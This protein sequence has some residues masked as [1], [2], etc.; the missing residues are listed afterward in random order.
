MQ[1]HKWSQKWGLHTPQS[2][3]ARARELGASEYLIQGLLPARSISLLIGDSGLGKSALVY[4]AGICISSGMPF[5]GRET[6]KGSVL[7]ADFEN[8]IVDMDELI[9]R[10]SK[11]IGLP[12]PPSELTLF[13]IND[14]DQHFGETGHEL[15]DVLRDLKPK[16]AII[17]SM[18]SYSRG[19]EE[20]NSAAI[21]MLQSFRDLIR[22]CGT[23]VLLVHHRRKLSRK[24]G[25]SAGPLEKAQ[26]R[27]W[28]QD[29]R[30][31]STLV[32]NSD[33]RL[34][35]DDP[36]LSAVSKDEIALV[37]R[38]FGRIRG[39]IGPVYLAREMDEHGDPMAYR[40]ITGAELL[41]NTDQQN[42]L[43]ALSD[44]FTFKDA[45]NAY[46]HA[47]QATRN[48]L[49]RSIGLGLIR[50]SGRGRYQRLPAETARDNGASRADV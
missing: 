6:Q 36:D 9:Q 10:I 39:E 18:A 8:G 26:L 50:Q 13:T 34:G 15:L 21:A 42:A 22:E 25:E 7:I 32:N 2:L 16:L 17:D 40:L 29:A 24:P 4:Q 3:Q 5:L 33:V 35:V 41:F 12:E 44:S 23:A 14:C 28:F 31:A 43:R 27:E 45:K 49:V 20:K 30:G 47:D 48:W 46:G 1:A 11:H 38:G 19:A 37:L